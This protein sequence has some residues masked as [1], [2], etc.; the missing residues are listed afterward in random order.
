MD[1]TVFINRFNA[2][3]EE[4]CKDLVIAFPEV[5]EFKQ[6]KSGLLLLKNVNE[7]QPRE[8]FQKF[9]ADHFRTEILNKDESF[10][11]NEVHNHNLLGG[12]GSQWQTVL[13]LIRGLWGGLSTTNKDNIWKYFQVLLAI[14]DRCAA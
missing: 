12:E 7:K 4:F 10:F 3:A 5:N 9:V 1:K 13:T 2:T 6:L 14:N 8:L 11:L